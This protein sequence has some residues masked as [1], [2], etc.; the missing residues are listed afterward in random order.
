MNR[1]SV[2]GFFIRRS[3]KL[4]ARYLHF[5]RAWP[6]CALHVSSLEKLDFELLRQNLL[7]LE[8]LFLKSVLFSR[9]LTESHSF[10]S[11][12]LFE[13]NR[14]VF[15][16]FCVSVDGFFHVGSWMKTSFQLILHGDAV[17]RGRSQWL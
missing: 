17:H 14:K 11:V 7:S 5:I 12:D 3:S 16:L 13:N 2:V 10:L 6:I 8:R 9:Q 1:G 4:T 15:V